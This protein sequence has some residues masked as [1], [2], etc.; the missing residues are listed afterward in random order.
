MRIITGLFDTGEPAIFDNVI[1]K[2]RI[3]AETKGEYK[4]NAREPDLA[5]SKK[6]AELFTADFGVSEIKFEE[7]TQEF[8]LDNS[9]PF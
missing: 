5:W 6:V 3:R 7:F 2:W 8:P 4:F 1:G 9:E